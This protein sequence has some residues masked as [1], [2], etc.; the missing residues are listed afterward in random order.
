[1]DNLTQGFYDEL[2]KRAGSFGLKKV[3]RMS[4][5][6]TKKTDNLYKKIRTD[7]PQMKLRDQLLL[8]HRLSNKGKIGKLQEASHQKLDKYILKKKFRGLD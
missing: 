6:L 2:E 1:M 7:N 4:K 3:L 8:H 5:N